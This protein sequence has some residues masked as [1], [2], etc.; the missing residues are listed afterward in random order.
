MLN[1]YTQ[2]DFKE[3]IMELKN[4]NLSNRQIAKELNCNESTIRRKLNEIKNDALDDAPQEQ[5][6]APFNLTDWFNE[7]KEIKNDAPQEQNDARKLNEIKNDAL[8]DAPQEQ[9]DAPLS[10]ADELIWKQIVKT[11]NDE[12]EKYGLTK[13]DIE[14]WKLWK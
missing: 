14:I 1:T 12:P 5:N 9:N 4:K 13:K 2:K 8:D 10:S 7:D 6:D 11:C 3:K